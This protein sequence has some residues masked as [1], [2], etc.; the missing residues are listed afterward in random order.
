MQFAHAEVKGTRREGRLTAAKN[1]WTLETDARFDGSYMP[2]CRSC[3]ATGPNL[4]G[5]L[6]SCTIAGFYENGI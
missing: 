4:A 2:A 3:C 6:R 1:V 5:T